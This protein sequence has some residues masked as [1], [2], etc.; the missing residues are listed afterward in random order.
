[1]IQGRNGDGEWITIDTR[2]DNEALHGRDKLQALF[3]CNGDSR[4]AYR[5]IRLWHAG[6]TH[7]S[8]HYHFLISQLEM[9]GLLCTRS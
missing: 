4:T 3:S 6:P 1:M 2:M 7:S 5:Y 9:F 8:Q